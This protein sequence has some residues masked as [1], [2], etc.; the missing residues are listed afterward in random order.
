[1][2]KCHYVNHAILFIF[3]MVCLSTVSMPRAMAGI[4]D[5][6]LSAQELAQSIDQLESII[7]VVEKE[8]A[9][10]IAMPFFNLYPAFT[11]KLLGNAI[12]YLPVI[13]KILAQYHLPDDLKFL[14]LF[15][16]SFRID[17]V[18]RAGAKGLWQFMAST[19]RKY[20]LTIN[21]EIDERLDFIK[22][23]E[24]AAKFLKELYEEFGDWSLVL[25]AYNGGPYRIKKIIENQ[26]TQDVKTIMRHMPKES[27]TYLSKMIAAKL[28]FQKYEE[29]NL[30]PQFPMEEDLYYTHKVF[31]SKIDLREISREYG[32]KQSTLASFN[33]H[34]KQR[35]F[36]NIA[37]IPVNI[38]IPMYENDTNPRFR[39]VS[40]FLKN[41]E[42]LAILAS[43]IDWDTRKIELY[44][45]RYNPEYPLAQIITI[46][47]PENKY[48]S[49]IK[50]FGPGPLEFLRNDVRLSGHLKNSKQRLAQYGLSL[51]AAHSQVYYLSP[52][53]T[54][55]DVAQKLNISIKTIKELNPDLNLYQSTKILIPQQEEWPLAM[56]SHTAQGDAYVRNRSRNSN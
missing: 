30:H 5:D 3:S 32:I 45:G 1:M 44:N 51:A 17:A 21:S 26:G 38:R 16:S 7:P 36:Q 48:L 15:E 29:Y 54:L 50:E 14:P 41:K 39:E 49:I 9:I 35:I 34:I 6:K 11:E 20:G 10:D 31:N 18:S 42:D 53:E 52:T 23:T 8:K 37:Q 13:E 22:S 12:I 56:G 47:V 24:A 4:M 43:R 19:G 28:I 55:I 40:L 46:P 33:P 2:Q 25:M 27:Q